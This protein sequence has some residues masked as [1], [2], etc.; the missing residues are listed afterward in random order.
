M[1]NMQVTLVLGAVGDDP[2]PAG[3]DHEFD[4]SQVDLCVAAGWRVINPP[5]LPDDFAWPEGAVPCLIV[6]DHAFV[7][8]EAEEGVPLPRVNAG[9]GTS[10]GVTMED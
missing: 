8:M 6:T 2:D 10:D 9:Y 7:W 5:L 1:A 4:W 3:E